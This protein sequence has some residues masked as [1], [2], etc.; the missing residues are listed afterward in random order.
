MWTLYVV[1]S[2]ELALP[3]LEQKQ[4]LQRLKTFPTVKDK[5]RT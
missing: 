1:V 4:T 2:A 5:H 3:F